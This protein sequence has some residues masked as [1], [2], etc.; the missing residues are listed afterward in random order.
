MLNRAYSTALLF[1]AAVFVI[2]AITPRILPETGLTMSAGRRPL[3]RRAYGKCR[4]TGP[5]PPTRVERGFGMV[6]MMEGGARLG[7]RPN[8]KRRGGLPRG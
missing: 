2:V 5:T 6:G 8:E 7:G 1:V 3:P 4:N